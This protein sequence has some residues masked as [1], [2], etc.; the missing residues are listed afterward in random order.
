M[1]AHHVHYCMTHRPATH[2]PIGAPAESRLALQP[3]HTALIPHQVTGKFAG[4]SY[5]LPLFGW[6]SWENIVPSPTA[7]PDTVAIGLDDGGGLHQA[8]SALD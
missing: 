3:P 8:V 2:P 6:D 4:N 5:Q 7:G 1:D